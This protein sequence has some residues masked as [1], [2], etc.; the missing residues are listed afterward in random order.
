M[1]LVKETIENLK[2]QIDNCKSVFNAMTEEI[3]SIRTRLNNDSNYQLFVNGTDI[4]RELND[5]LQKILDLQTSLNENEINNI[6]TNC[7]NFVA[8]QEQLNESGE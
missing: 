4:G 5:K 3:S 2:N 6:I 1:A 8:V 7:S